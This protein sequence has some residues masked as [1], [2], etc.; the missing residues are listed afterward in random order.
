[1]RQKRHA[2]KTK[3]KQKLTFVD[4]EKRGLDAPFGATKAQ[5]A[6]YQRLRDIKN[7]IFEARQGVKKF[8]ARVVILELTE[9]Q[10]DFLS[11]LGF[12]GDLYS[13]TSGELALKF[14]LSMAMFQNGQRPL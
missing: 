13:N 4:G 3:T 2:K 7:L 1:M 12:P 5:A 6:E 10:D 11:D 8:D 9:A 14:I